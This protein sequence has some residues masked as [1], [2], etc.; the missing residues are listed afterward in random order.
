MHILLSRDLPR[1]SCLFISNLV[2]TM[3]DNSGSCTIDSG[4][5]GSSHAS[6]GEEAN[7]GTAFHG[8][9]YKLYFFFVSEDAKNLRVRC[10]LCV[11]NKTLLSAKNTTSNFKKNL[12]GVHKNTVL[13]AKEVEKPE[14]R[15]WRNETDGDCND[16]EPK[17]QCTLPTMLNRHS[18]PVD[19]L[20]SLLAEYVI[21]DMQP[22]STVDS[23]AFR[24]FLGSICPTQLPDIK[25]FT[26]YLDTV[27]D[28]MVSKIKKTLEAIDIVSTTVDVWSAHHRSYLGMIVHWINPH[29]LKRCKAVIACA[30]MM[31]WHTYDV[32]ACK[33]EQVYASY[34]LTRKVCATIT[35]NGSNFEKVF[36]IYSDSPATPLEDVEKETEDDAAFE[37][38]D[39]LLTFDSEETNI[40][41]HL[42]QV[43][44]ELP[45]HY[46]GAAHMVN[47][48]ASKDADK[49]LLPSSTP[50]GVYHSSF[51]KSS[52][53][54][55]KASRLT[56]ASDTV[57]EAYCTYCYKVEL[58][59]WCSSSSYWQFISRVKWALYQARAAVF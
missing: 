53:L 47:L 26:V 39:D 4:S 12:N 19:K 43:Q 58:I 54:W 31:G 44:Y 45:L 8:W 21:E 14:K 20:Q 7:T 5:P 6:S 23:P 10:T 37:N 33:I 22:L 38:V 34:G 11:G 42:T 16:G 28:W 46:R 2:A 27:Y 50:K 25:S 59:L 9:K 51:A 1:A 30:R 49:F 35:D 13:V 57:Q 56:V 17:R 3:G 29:T 52:A 36:T 41:D 48:I 18:I 15:K 40:D 32:L 24:K 55:N